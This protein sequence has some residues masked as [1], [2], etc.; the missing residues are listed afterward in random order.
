MLCCAQSLSHVRLSVTPWTIAHQTPLFMGILQARIL[1]GLP[2]PPL[3]DL[4]NPG[5]KPRSPTFQVD[6]LPFKSP[7]KS[8]NTDMGSISLLQM[9]F[10]TQESNQG[11]LEFQVDSLPAELPGKP[12]KSTILQYTIKLFKSHYVFSIKKIK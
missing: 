9:I 12:H 5:T 10:P 1:D 3:W 11:L 8:M 7:G 6:S 2:C 4:P